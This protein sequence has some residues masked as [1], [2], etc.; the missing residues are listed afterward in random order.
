MFYIVDIASSDDDPF[1]MTGFSIATSTGDLCCARIE[2]RKRVNME[3][4]KVLP[5]DG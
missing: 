4:Q 1:Q 5:I 3:I 2:V